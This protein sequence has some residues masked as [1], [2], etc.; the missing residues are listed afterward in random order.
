M[1]PTHIPHVI[2]LF[3]FSFLINPSA[4]TDEILTNTQTCGRGLP[5]TPFALDALVICPDPS[6]ESTISDPLTLAPWT[7]APYCIEAADSPWCVFTNAAA[8]AG[9]GISIITTPALA[10]DA[11]SILHS[12]FDRPFQDPEKAYGT[13]PYEVRDVPGKG[14]GAVANQK[15]EAGR[16]VLV[17]HA[18]V[19]AAVE[20]PADVTK[21]E[22][23]ELMREAVARLADPG[24]ILNLSR[25][26][27]D[28]EGVAE[29]EDLLLTN[30]FVVPL[31]GELVMG[32]FPNLA[33]INHACDP[34]AFVHFSEVTLA[35]TIWSARDIEPGEEITISYS[36]PT[37]T[38]EERQDALLNI[39]GFKCTCDMCTA[40][41][42]HR[43][44]S[45][46]R[47]R[48]LRQLQ[49]DVIDQAQRGEFREAIQTVEEIFRVVEVEKLT[50]HMG[51]MYEIPARLY[52]HIGDVDRAVE[53]TKKSLA[54]ARDFGVPGPKGRERIEM[55]EKII[56]GMEGELLAREK[57]Q[58]GGDG[59]FDAW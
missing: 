32:L 53:Y 9:H 35:M 58:R 37:A 55:L 26:G 3:L 51:D 39:W 24:C 6:P 34:N 13:R 16:V 52:Y 1:A 57:G 8:P 18:A 15:I 17:D 2:A 33:R 54:E 41:P 27:R 40:P 47:R 29:V 42:A 4:A 7:H 48:A 43:G 21:E 59:G 23:Q 46:T 30:S 25:K 22:V 36:D 5:S 10:A 11:L 28:E 56:A 12:Q 31:G 44:A 20:Y 49:K 50:V 19:L 14:K 38:Y 45:D